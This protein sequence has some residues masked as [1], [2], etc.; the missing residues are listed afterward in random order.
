MKTTKTQAVLF[1]YDLFQQRG[2]VSKQDFLNELEIS[3]SSFKRYISELRI[4]FTN[5][6]CYKD[7]AYHK[8]NDSYLLVDY[9]KEGYGCK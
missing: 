7:I 1:L 5:F 9:T 8:K 4:Y 6:D 2:E 3:P